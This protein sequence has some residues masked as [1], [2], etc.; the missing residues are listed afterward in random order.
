[1]AKKMVSYRLEENRLEELTALAA[2]KGVP[3]AQLLE[4]LIR[5]YWK[6]QRGEL[7]ELHG[8]KPYSCNSEHENFYDPSRL[9]GWDISVSEWVDEMLGLHQGK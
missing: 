3:V 6:E 1:M 7:G 2:L 8:Y 9:A 4:A 5:A